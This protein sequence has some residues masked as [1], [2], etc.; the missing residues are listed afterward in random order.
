MPLR[1]SLAF[2]PSH[3]AFGG[4]CIALLTGAGAL[5]QDGARP[6]LSLPVDCALGETCFVQQMPDMDASEARTDPFCGSATYDGHKGTDFRV[7]SM[8]DLSPGIDALAAAPGTVLRVRDGEPDRL[9]AD[10]AG[11][12]EIEGRECGN[13]VV[14]EHAGGLRTLTCHLRSGSVRVEPGQEVARGEAIGIVGASGLAAFPHI[15]FEVIGPDGSI[16]PFTG[17]TVGGG[18]E[19]THTAD[20]TAPL[21]HPADAAAIG[22]P[23]AQL[24][25]V[26]LA[27]GPVSPDALVSSG[28]PAAPEGDEPAAV[29]VYAWA[30]NLRDGDTMRLRLEN[31]DGEVASDETVIEGDKAQWV[32]FAGRRNPG[33]GP[34]TGTVE[35]LREGETILEG[36]VP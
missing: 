17:K 4:V 6:L 15:Q 19:A 5:A 22:R 29:V 3:L 28:P 20:N 10:E 11:A 21:W 34:F 14:I 25:S 13:G 8:A 18:C 7:L 9:V 2:R 31:P 36:S 16:D 33:P 26:G 23:G 24:L 12:S 30:I 1:P 32:A 35:V 27:D